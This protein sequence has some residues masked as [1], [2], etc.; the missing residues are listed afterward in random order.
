MRPDLIFMLTRDDRTVPDAGRHVEAALA[1]GVRHIG[2]KDI[3][4]PAPAMRALV[5]AIHA[6]GGTAYLEMVSLERERER[7][8][9]AEAAA[10]GIDCLLGGIHPEAVLLEILGGAIRYRPFAG[11]VSDHP[12]TLHGTPEAI[13]ESARHLAAMEGV[14]GLDLLA[15]RH[16]G[17]VPALIR[18]VCTAVA[19]PVV[20]AGSID[21]A[22]RIA[23]SVAAGAAAITVGTAAFARRFVPEADD[24]G[25]QLRAILAALAAAGDAGA[26][27][28]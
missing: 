24:L 1:A 12:S 2:F 20:V 3:G 26:P 10:A 17:P 18:A 16:A 28:R 19:K 15:Y 13:T 9:A 14:D 6:G 7:A 8:A 25:T 27:T 21:S 4:L 5:E 22:G 11:T 23:E